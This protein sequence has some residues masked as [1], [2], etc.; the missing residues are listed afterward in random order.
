M[1]IL[2]TCPC[3]SNNAIEECCARYING[4]A[5][6]T[7]EA[8]MR[9]RYTAYV[10][11]NIDYIAATMR[12]NAAKDFNQEEAKNW[13]QQITW[14]GLTIIKAKPPGKHLTTGTVEFVALYRHEGRLHRMHEVSKFK[15]IQG[16]WYYMD[17][18]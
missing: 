8:L 17:G 13:C 9:S 14:E 11:A 18:S 5:A 2:K 1:A 6:P 16:R 15:R 3:G 7:P 12:G 10:Q 4:D